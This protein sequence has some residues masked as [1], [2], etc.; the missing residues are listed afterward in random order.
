MKIAV[1][2]KGGVGKT[3]LSGMLAATMA[4][5]G[6]NVIALDADPDANLAA[7]VGI[8]PDEQPTP[9]SEMQDL[10]AERTGAKGNYGGYFKLNPKVDDIPETYAAKLG[11]IRMLALGGI[12]KGGGGC[13]CPA[14]ALVKAL[15]THLVLGREDAIIMDM[16]AGIEHLGRATAQGMDAFVIVVNQSRWSVETAHRIRKLA[17]DLGMKNLFA[18]ANGVGDGSAADRIAEELDGIP[19]V[20]QIPF[21]PRL[22]SAMLKLADDGR[23]TATE[24]LAANREA[25]ESILS[26]LSSEIGGG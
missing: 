25:I 18:V 4:L 6:H 13:I 20:G 9:L 7:A 5:D 1:S 24:G 21:D 10:I 23:L 16:E 19:L 14:S 2:G 3:T 17:G 11:P 26:R 15:L 8:S 22:Q 12:K